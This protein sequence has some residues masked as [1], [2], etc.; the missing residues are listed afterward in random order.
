[1][2]EMIIL[3]ILR[4]IG[5]TDSEV[6]VYLALLK[7]GIASKGKIIKNANISGSKIYE[8]TDKLIY[9]GLCSIIIKNG[10]KHF[11]V[12]PPSRIQDFLNKKKN[13]IL[14][15][16]R[17]FE[18]IISELD[19]FYKKMPED[20]KAEVFIGW[21]G[22]ETVYSTLL[23][24]SKRGDN[25]YILGAGTGK[26][27]KKLELF[28]TKY[29]RISLKKGLNVRVIFNESARNYVSK[30]EKNIKNRYNKKFLF[31]HTPTEILIFKNATAIIIQREEPIVILIRD[32]ETAISF[33]KYF[34]ELWKIAKV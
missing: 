12:A 18:K 20:V 23:D 11:M 7:L 29:G 26:D 5:L 14:E 34:E 15:E 31:E 22:M 30:I 33:I 27:E 2:E 8:V 3:N 17:D 19:N 28:Y 21:K 13:E 25:V 6:K 1:M 10:V 4:R 24:Q 32:N 9:K 16:E